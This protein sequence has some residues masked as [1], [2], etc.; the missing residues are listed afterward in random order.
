M[1][2]LLV[3][4][5]LGTPQ[6]LLNDKVVS[7]D[8]R[9]AIALLAYLAINDIR[10]ARQKYPRE[11]LSALLWPDYEQAKAFSNLRRTIWEVHQ[12]VGENWL[13]TDRESV[14]FN[15]GAESGQ[16]LHL[17]VARFRE[18]IS[19]SHQQKE[20]SLRVEILSDAAELY[21]DHLLTGF[22]LKDA[23]G[24]NEWAFAESE[25]LR[26]QLGEALTM[27]SNDHI[28]LGKAAEAIPYA[29][30][31][32]ALEP[33]NE[34]SHRL[35]MQVYL[36]AGQ[37]STALK[38]YQI[39]EQILRKELGVDPQPET[40]ALYKQIRRGDVKPV[41]ASRVVEPGTPRHNLPIQLST[42]IGRKKEQQEIGDLIAR[43]RLVT[44]TGAGGIGKTR[45]SIQAASARLQ[46]Y[47][48]GTWLVEL[49]PLTEKALVPQA[50]VTALGLSEQTDLPSL[51]VLTNF[52]QSRRV[53]LLLDNC[54]HLIDACAQLTETLLSTCPNLHILATSREALG[55]SGETIYLVPP[56]STP[57]A[58]VALEQFSSYEAVQLFME[59]AQTIVPAFAMTNQ[60]APAIAQI[61]HHLDG[62]PLAIELAAARVKMFSVQE[63]A[64]RLDD[65]FNLLTAGMRTALPR[66]QTLRALIDWSHELLS[67]RERFLLR[68]LSVFA[69][70]WTLEA[71]EFVCAGE[72]IESHQILDLLTQLLN[73]SL[74]FTE[75]SHGQETRY[76]MLETIRQHAREKLWAAGE[77]NLIRQRHLEYYVG[78]A[79]Q[80]EPHLRASEMVWWL[81]RLE[82]ELGN[83]RA[84]LEW[85][86]EGDIQAQ[87]RLAG[88][89]LWFWH[90]RRHQ[91]E[92]LEWLERGLSVEAMERGDQPLT[93]S[94]AMVRGKALNT[95]GF[96]LAML[97]ESKRASAR[98]EESLALFRELGSAGK[99][100]MAYALLRLG[101]LQSPGSRQ[102]MLEQSLGLFRE[103]GDKFGIAEC[104]LNLT[105]IAQRDD[106]YTKRASQLVEEQVA[107]REEIGDRDGRA[108]ALVQQGSLAFWQGE[109][110]RAANLFEESLAG[111][112]ELNNTAAMSYVLS[113]YA[114][115]FL[116]LGEYERVKRIS[117]ETL[118]YA[119][120]KGERFLIA[121]YDYS[122]GFLHWSQGDYPAATQMFRD[123]L[124]IAREV[125]NSWFIT[126][127]LH[128]LGDIASAQ[129]DVDGAAHC[130][131]EE[132]QVAREKQ[133]E[134]SLVFTPGSLG[135]VAWMKGE[136]MKAKE[137]FSKSL[138]LGKA[139]DC[140]PA[141]FQAV[142]GLGRVA[143]SQ[144]DP[145][146][147]RAFYKEGLEMQRSQINV[148]FY[149][150]W[151]TT[152]R[153]SISYPL[154]GLATLAVAAKQMERAT[155]L[156][157][158]AEHLYRQL[159]F[160]MS[161][162]ERA[163]RNQAIGAAWL[164]L[165]EKAF[166]AAYEEGK[167]MTMDEAVALAL[168]ES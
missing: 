66:H 110:T 63:I 117:Y 120:S 3:L 121:F 146:T 37:H 39:C 152:Y 42:F 162:K 52:L 80:A 70:G 41:Q 155:H 168:Q 93:S 161:A 24:F 116:W 158:A 102:S 137:E 8:R 74:I 134:I 59:R 113:A 10:H 29:R 31:L 143:Q 81:D 136:Y 32:V 36:Q 119:Q 96:L 132:L 106:H 160:E 124:A 49:A 164:A 141:I 2:S 19:Q 88:A 7:T 14:Q 65:R 55:I 21:R 133:H 25:E 54:E 90:I 103:I 107:L 28:S 1:S 148:A 33:L 38:Q 87:L 97:F 163:E 61:C 35:L 77:G 79:E 123:G 48:D 45:L 131:E 118:M 111:F 92:G 129:D 46:E 23:P 109:Y 157:G 51:T 64:A 47:P 18:L 144:G 12:A 22:S 11:A 95:A 84:A 68:R 165:G 26:R 135:K 62:I 13:L 91:S 101:G 108:L 4:Q 73:K 72:G 139:T 167:K 166:T 138:E 86:L 30:R 115:D 151:L 94:R 58:E 149:W 122:M 5:F 153:H 98:L 159:H 104:L 150:L 9:K 130:Y 67:E 82:E 69:G 17:D 34:A 125:G 147:A 128:A 20:P 56:L 78:L 60:N 112:R 57:A 53:L 83:I 85:S 145:V 27:L 105:D 89:L 99:Q 127:S 154:V 156:F 75:Q 15:D 126:N 71:A 142:Y 16:D 76:L 50:V 6:V 114:A 40:Y 43:N 100:G 140:K 44:L